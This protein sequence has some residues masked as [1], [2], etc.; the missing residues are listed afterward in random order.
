MLIAFLIFFGVILLILLIP[1]GAEISSD[2]GIRRYYLSIA[3]IKFRFSPKLRHARAVGSEIPSK[4]MNPPDIFERLDALR[5][6]SVRTWEYYDVRLRGKLWKILKR[7]YRALHIRIHRCDLSIG[8]QDPA[9]TGAVYGMACAIA[10]AIP[11]WIP[12]RLT[13]DFE[14]GR[15]VL[16]YRI[17]LTV[18]PAELL[19]EF[20]R[21]I[22]S[23]R[24]WSIP[25]LLRGANP[26]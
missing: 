7:C 21:T 20:T 1:V 9:A 15:T 2:Q 8:F 12:L 10:A 4:E 17:S 23:L 6:S 22:I 5:E 11:K 24:L 16:D 19:F 3:G 13:P 26:R 14:T 25:R 18:I